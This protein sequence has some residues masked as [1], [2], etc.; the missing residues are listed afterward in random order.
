L[1]C[2]IASPRATNFFGYGYDV[3]EF[4]VRGFGDREFVGA[5][6][7]GVIFGFTFIEAESKLLLPE[8]GDKFS[9]EQKNEADVG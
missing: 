2:W 4:R 7:F 9:D 3:V 5:V 6:A 1:P 8:P